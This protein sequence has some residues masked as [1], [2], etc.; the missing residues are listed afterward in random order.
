[1]IQDF[2]ASWHLFHNSYLAGWLIG[3]LLALIGVLVVARNQIFIGVAVS[4]ASTLGIALTMWLGG[5]RAA[6]RF[7]RRILEPHHGR[8]VFGDRGADHRARGRGK[9]RDPR[10]HHRLGLSPGG[11]RRHSHRVA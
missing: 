7:H 6:L 10:G 11:Q 5:F 2:A 4:Q 1:M 3:L 8:S 9:Y